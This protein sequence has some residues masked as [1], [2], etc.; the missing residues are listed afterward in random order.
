[1][2][3]RH[4]HLGVLV[5][6]P[7]LFVMKPLT[8]I[9]YQMHQTSFSPYFLQI[10]FTIKFQMLFLFYLAHLVERESWHFYDR[11]VFFN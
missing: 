7:P 8:I 2:N 3:N 10:D 6:F 4:D 1:M 11:L 5:S 9:L